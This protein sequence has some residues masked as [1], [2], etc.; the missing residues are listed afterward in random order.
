MSAGLSKATSDLKT[1]GTE[2]QSTGS[3]VKQSG[4]GIGAGIALITTNL[5]NTINSVIGLKRQWEDLKRSQ[6]N[7]TQSGFSL[8]NAQGKLKTATLNLQAAKKGDAGASKQEIEI[9]Q[10]QFKEDMKNAKSKLDVMKAHEKLNKVMNQGGIDTDKLTKKQIAYDRALRGVKSA[11]I[12]QKEAQVNL[13]RATE[14]FYLQTIPTAVG[15][16]GSFGSVLQVVQGGGGIGGVTKSIAKFSLVGVGLAGVFLAIKSNFLGFR[17]ALTG[18]GKN[19]GDAVPALKPFLNIL[20]SV[21]ELLGLVPPKKGQK[22]G[23]GLNK[24]IKDLQAQFGP[25]IGFF[26]R[27][28]DDIMKGDWSKV[29]QRIVG[30]AQIAWKELKKA[31]PILGDIESLVNKIMN[32]NWKGALLQIWK[33]AVD[34]WIAIKNAFPIFGDIE[35]LVLA[36]SQGKWGDAFKAIQKAVTDSGLPAVIDKIF[37]EDWIANVT[38]RIQS[39]PAILTA[40]A[41][42]AKAA[43]DKGDWKGVGAAIGGGIQEGMKASG[44]QQV[45]DFM[46][47]L[48]IGP[49]AILAAMKDQKQVKMWADI[50]TEIGK[51]LSAVVKNV[52]DPFVASLL[53]PTNWITAFQAGAKNLGQIATALMNALFP[54][55]K[56][57]GLPA[58]TTLAGTFMT[59]FFT[60]IGNWI[61]ENNP[62]TVAAIKSL[63]AG[64]SKAIIDAGKNIMLLG[65]GIVTAIIKGLTD[66]FTPENL[67]KVVRGIISAFS[68]AISDSAKSIKQIGIVIGNKIGEGIRQALLAIV[69]ALPFFP[70]SAADQARKQ[71]NAGIHASGFHGY[72]SGGQLMSAGER[73]IEKVDITPMSDIVNRRDKQGNGGGTSTIIV[74]SVLDGQVIAESVAKRISVNQ[75]V[76]R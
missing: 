61:V 18:L 11:T 6:D 31:F 14:D 46:T 4:I 17:D 70:G 1:M 7:V 13:K 44:G 39:I 66:N 69:N 58:A 12:N 35:S 75:A 51:Q 42:L 37:G 22:A 5:V 3:K 71:L 54:K 43:A 50:G 45:L 25:L 55:D 26:Q 27:V 8:A 57:G 36:I 63:I 16:V 23:A 53:T 72:V 28:I 59:S 52:I 56:G 20:E 67:A 10:L 74:Y 21:G 19:L 68:K 73:G 40:S 15:V 41:G 76:Y 65:K 24:A 2:A 32:G 38:T 62:K 47:N 64:F 49:A 9:A 34:V 29:F 60:G 33:A 30:A 48:G